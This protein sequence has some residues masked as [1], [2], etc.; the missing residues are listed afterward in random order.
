MPEVRRKRI[1][2]LIEILDKNERK[3]IKTI[4]GPKDQED[5][6]K[7]ISNKRTTHGNREYNKKK[8]NFILLSP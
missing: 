2:G 3:I 1:Q 7:L 5:Q 6:I 8:T 4:L